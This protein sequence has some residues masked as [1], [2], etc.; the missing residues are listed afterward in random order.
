[1]NS[2]PASRFASLAFLAAATTA[3]ATTT[4][5]GCA[6]SG[7]ASDVE[8]SMHDGDYAQ[9]VQV[10]AQWREREPDNSAA[11]DAHKRASAAYLVDQG[12]TALFTKRE[13]EAL[14]SFEAAQEILPG[15]AVVA[16]WVRKARRELAQ[17]WLDHAVELAA[18]DELEPAVDA[19]EKVLQYD[20]G[21]LVA[22]EGASRALLQLNWRGG[23]GE[24]YYKEG[25]RA[26]REFWL[27]RAK[28]HFDYTKKY[29]GDSE[30]T[31][32][33]QAEVLHLMAQDRVAMAEELERKGL[34][35]AAHNEY[36]LALLI[37]PKEATALAARARLGVEIEASKLELEVERML[38]K[39]DWDGALAAAEKARSL[40]KS[41]F[42]AFDALARRVEDGRLDAEYEAA[43]DMEHDYRYEEAA[44][45]YSAL[46]E[47]VG[48][49]KDCRERREAL[50]STIEQ[51]GALYEQA[52][53]AAP[54]EALSLYRQVDLLWPDWRDV[55]QH[56]QRLQG[57]LGSAPAAR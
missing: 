1:M 20:P 42:A 7:A 47:R 29:L 3:L 9:A 10:A 31:Q 13:E 4:L 12:R 33:R 48:L 21:S 52:R 25:V 22:R 17:R 55:R 27:V 53:A 6:T 24:T 54:A 5:S 34:F 30:R 44:K 26:L 28:T 11:L 37:D 19:Y 56:I 46:M 50:R 14:Q 23:V 35:W 43:R 40:T 18:R 32:D 57:E 2:K 16:D 49:Y 39:K 15:D 51:A 38:R 36:R 41:R 8:R 45:A